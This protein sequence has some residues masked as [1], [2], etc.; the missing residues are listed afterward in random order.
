MMNWM[1]RREFIYSL[2]ALASAPPTCLLGKSRQTG[3]IQAGPLIETEKEALAEICEQIVPQDEF[4]GAKE[5]GVDEFISRLLTEAHPDWLIVYRSGLRSTDR[6]SRAVFQRPFSQISFEERTQLLERM[7]KG[8]LDLVDWGA[9]PPEEFFAMVRSHSIQGYYSHP[10]WGG[11]R[12]KKA[13]AMLDY[14]D[15][16]V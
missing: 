16:W 2:A 12:D 10:R 4:P 6:S 14:D 9:F 7:S 1:D 13:W 8:D 3:A 15:W 5:L 11:N